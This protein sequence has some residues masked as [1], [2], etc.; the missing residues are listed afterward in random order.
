MKQ[1]VSLG[2]VVILG[3]LML[4]ASHAAIERPRRA[5]TLWQLPEQTHSQMMS[6]VIRTVGGK[7]LVIDGGM[8]GD[9]PYLRGF[10]AA[11]GN[12]VDVWIVS[13]QH[14]DHMGALGEIL[15][16]PRDL[17]IGRIYS[18]TLDA[19]WIG[20]YCDDG[21]Y[22]SWIKF[23]EALRAA[24]RRII[25]L[26]TGRRMTLDGVSIEVLGVANPEIHA[27]GINNSSLVL[28][29]WDSSKSILFLGDLGPEGGAKLLEGKY[30][31]RLDCDYVQ[32]AHHGQ[33]GVSLDVYQAAS[34]QYCLWPTPTW[35]WDNNIG[36]KGKGSGPW[37][38]LEV[39]AWMEQL[40]V[41][42]NYVSA[43]GLHQ[44]D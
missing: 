30:R 36:G 42:A 14:D 17:K 33:N 39:R 31:S 12:K 21:D 7:V 9:A 38:T 28:R 11:L 23:Q 32:M 27:N 1:A 29:V 18:S 43:D 35:L 26:R 2:L 40:R 6:Y 4:V 15:R 19:E 5:F 34:P 20:K 16:Q 8:P 25:E 13:H 22:R 3:S 24:G 37:R 10:L 41:E 44:I